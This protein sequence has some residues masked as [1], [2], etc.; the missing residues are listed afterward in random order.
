M[1]FMDN[2]DQIHN[3]FDNF[4]LKYLDEVIDEKKAKDFENKVLP[5][6]VSAH[7]VLERNRFV[8]VPENYIIVTF[9]RD[10]N[11]LGLDTG[12]SKSGIERKCKNPTI[13]FLY[14]WIQYLQYCANLSN[15]SDV[16]I[17]T[18]IKDNI[19]MLDDKI[20]KYRQ[21]VEPIFKNAPDATH[22]FYPN[23]VISDSKFSISNDTRQQLRLGITDWKTMLTEGPETCFLGSDYDE[24]ALSEEHLFK[25]FER[26]IAKKI[27]HD[28]YDE[29]QK[30]ILLSELLNFMVEKTGLSSK[31]RRGTQQKKI[32]KV[33]FL[34]SCR[35]FIRDLTN[36]F[37]LKTWINPNPFKD[38]YNE[39]QK[40][41]KYH[42]QIDK[43]L[44][45]IRQLVLN[46][47]NISQP[48][49]L[50]L[51]E[52]SKFLYKYFFV[53]AMITTLHGEYIGITLEDVYTLQ[54]I[55]PNNQMNRN[56]A[57][58]ILVPVRNSEGQLIRMNHPMNPKNLNPL[59]KNSFFI[60]PNVSGYIV[61]K[62]CLSGPIIN[63][64]NSIYYDLMWNQKS[65]EYIFEKWAESI[66]PYLST[67]MTRL[68]RLEY[69]SNMKKLFVHKKEFRHIDKY[70]ML[71]NPMFVRGF[72]EMLL[73]V[74]DVFYYSLIELQSAVLNYKPFERIKK[75]NVETQYLK[76]PFIDK[77]HWPLWTAVYNYSLLYKDFPYETPF[78]YAF[79]NYR[80][81]DEKGNSVINNLMNNPVSSSVYDIENLMEIY[82]SGFK[83][84][85]YNFHGLLGLYREFWINVFLPLQKIMSKYTVDNSVRLEY[86]MGTYS[87][88]ILISLVHASNSM[89]SNFRLP[90]GFLRYI[91]TFDGY[92]VICG[93]YLMEQASKRIA[94]MSVN[95]SNLS[96]PS[97]SSLTVNQS[98]SA[99]ASISSLPSSSSSADPSTAKVVVMRQVYNLDKR[100][101]TAN[102]I[103]KPL[104]P[105]RIPIRPNSTSLDGHLMKNATTNVSTNVTTQ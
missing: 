45:E 102:I 58:N 99:D 29:T 35:G 84:Y 5:V 74:P 34:I 105:H 85:E 39:F 17:Q 41:S 61:N 60:P 31:T 69:V 2:T 42:D 92:D 56:N 25:G 55:L 75:S 72:G 20:N 4:D 83:H 101:Q 73:N 77:S 18:I 81:V 80:W 12:R 86:V 52:T 14:Y 22:V 44:N 67:E 38:Y 28:Q 40:F 78:E 46:L 68:K 54:K 13:Q 66:D 9:Q 89:T 88:K 98:T 23:D 27:I 8:K 19:K 3:L 87:Y 103:L 76:F 70:K 63:L 94:T 64:V 91:E 10:G 49:Q 26:G 82:R 11:I 93:K 33:L 65:R 6:V 90:K 104:V 71:N 32:Y 100:P 53:G 24:F 16:D 62:G 57:I 79:A 21:E 48:D 15:E 50:K 43:K 30:N 37:T 96:L 51:F 59:L 7:G 97:T 47:K 1:L 95:P 36:T